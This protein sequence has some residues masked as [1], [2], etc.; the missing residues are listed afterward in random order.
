MERTITQQPDRGFTLL[1]LLI[2]VTILAILSVGA[3]LALGRGPGRDSDMALFRQ[4]HAQMRMLAIAGQQVRGL[5]I[6]PRGMTVAEYGPSGWSMAQTRI[7]WARR[8]ALSIAF[9]DQGAVDDPQILFLPSGRSTP[10]S[11]SFAGGGQC[12]SDGWS[13]LTCDG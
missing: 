9:A 6:E 13:T 8:A 2:T 3:V 10:F 11:L 1:E 12:R 7:S 5:R 4:T